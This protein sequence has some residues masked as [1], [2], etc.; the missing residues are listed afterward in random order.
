M[1]DSGHDPT[2]IEEGRYRADVVGGGTVETFWYYVIRRNDSNEVI[3]IATFEYS[4]QALNAARMA[5]ARMAREAAA[6]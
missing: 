6:G 4:E 2:R 3:Q 1:Q 5:L